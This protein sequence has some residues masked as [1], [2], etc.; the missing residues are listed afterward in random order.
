MIKSLLIENFSIIHHAHIQFVSGMSVIT[1]ETGAGKSLL[2]D[3]LDLLSTK[4][5]KRLSVR[6]G[7]QEANITL[8]VEI[9][10]IPTIQT[11]LANHVGD[12]Q[13]ANTLTLRRTISSGGRS[14]AWINDHSATLADLA[15]ATALLVEVCGQNTHHA[16]MRAENHLAILD[17]QCGHDKQTAELL[18]TAQQWNALQKQIDDIKQR[19]AESDSQR[20]LL[21][22]QI[23]E[24]NK[25]APEENEWE[26]IDA[27]HRLVSQHEDL[28]K[29]YG[30]GIDIIEDDE[31]GARTRLAAVAR[32]LGMFE[33]QSIKSVTQ[34]LE[35]VLVLMQSVSAELRQLLNETDRS[36]EQLRELES[37]LEKLSEVARKHKV[38][39]K[40][41][42]AHW[43]KMKEEIAQLEQC[44]E[45]LSEIE[46]QADKLSAHWNTLAKRISATRRKTA[47]ELE[48]GVV[49]ILKDLAMPNAIF[50][51]VF[52][53]TEKDT[54]PN[55]YGL[56]RATFH[57]QTNPGGA[58]NLL[59]NIASGGELSRISLALRAYMANKYPVPTLIFDEIESGVG[60]ETAGAVGILLKRMGQ[61][62]QVLCI[63]HL[64]QI[65]SRSEHHYRV[66]KH[67]TS[68]DTHIVLSK[69]KQDE[70]YH[71]IARMMAGKDITERSLAHA[72][73][74][75]E[76]NVKAL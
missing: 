26:R 30:H 27:E 49:K 20:A 32:E 17:R 71:E 67:S 13:P 63:T 52:E 60:G 64:A 23:D 75:L 55:A 76:R 66:E 35:E 46:E 44:S 4:R 48:K 24:L 70:R 72:R 9:D 54:R 3:A 51:V 73:E 33:T 31:K 41:L 6:Q 69:L 5:G 8:D 7:A 50:K 57:I 74:L 25:L 37:R 42:Y 47:G 40:D 43:Q 61:H 68:K 11:W 45:S 22:Y 34:Q 10:D 36:E 62:A 15:E 56:E 21:N 12:G 19:V 18:K 58:P 39:P 65:A 14:K 59:G 1:G 38:E 16:L 29:L 2:I 53:D 28:I